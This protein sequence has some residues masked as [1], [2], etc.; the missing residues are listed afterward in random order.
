MY[1][2]PDEIERR[3]LS[4]SE[5]RSEMSGE[6]TTITGYA[7]VFDTW[8]DIGG[9]FREKIAPGAFKKTLKESDIRALWN[10]DPNY[11]LG[12][13]KAGTLKLHEDERGL[14]VEIDPVG[15]TWATD[16]LKSIQRGDVNQMS[17]GFK[18]NKADDDYDENTR[19]LKDV[20]LFDV[21]VVTF[22]AYPTTTAEVRSAFTTKPKSEPELPLPVHDPLD[23]VLEKLRKREMITQEERQRIEPYI[24]QDPPAPAASHA[25]AEPEPAASH[26]DATDTRSKP[27]DRVQLLLAKAESIAPSIHKQTT[28]SRQE[29]YLT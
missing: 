24:Q 27:L 18:V 19:V 9:L 26:S 21:S 8:T 14:R 22:P 11:V 5:V 10:H 15:S 16:L 17:F 1:L 7:A 25:E 28:N 13:N 20:S 12:R 29:E 23:D 6:S 4:T 3:C 2:K